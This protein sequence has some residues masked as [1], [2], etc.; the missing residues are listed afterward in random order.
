MKDEINKVDNID[1]KDLFRK[2]EKIIK[3]RIPC[4]IIY[5]RKFSLIQKI[6]NRHWNVLQ[7]NPGLQEAFQSNLFVAFK[8]NKNL[9][10]IIEG[11]MIKNGK[12]F[13]AHLKDKKGKYEPC[14][15]SKP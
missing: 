4:L 14:N 11:H 12:V 9:Q 8:R 15:T 13:K 2:K 10:E 5:S 3:D 6:I 7:T 1:R